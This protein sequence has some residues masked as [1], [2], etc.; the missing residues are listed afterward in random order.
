MKKFLR[1]YENQVQG[2]SENDESEDQMIKSNDFVGF[3]T[4]QV[5]E[6]NQELSA[7][8]HLLRSVW[9]R[10]NL[11]IWQ[12]GDAKRHPWLYAQIESIEKAFTR[13]T[14]L[15][16]REKLQEL[17]RKF[18]AAKETAKGSVQAFGQ[19]S[20]QTAGESGKPNL[21]GGEMP[22]TLSVP[23]EK[24]NVVARGEHVAKID[25]IGPSEPSKFDPSKR[26]IKISFKVTEGDF[27]D[28]VLNKMYTEA[29]GSKSEL[30]KLWRRLFGDPQPGTE[31]DL[32]DMLDHSVAIVVT[33]KEGDDGDYAVIQDVFNAPVANTN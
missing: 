2:C 22:R 1:K 17:Y 28:S 23:E 3:S 9:K 10:L 31:V 32:E 27:T 29:M 25:V 4:G 20:E 21:K 14:Y 15:E 13:M 24:N 33:H 16:L 5:A 12:P 26:C 19:Y 6:E 11:D 30:G 18:V 7:K 8:L